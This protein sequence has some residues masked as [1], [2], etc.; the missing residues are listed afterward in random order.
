MVAAMR[1]TMAAMI[2]GGGTNRY[3]SVSRPISPRLVSTG[4]LGIG[5]HDQGLK[6]VVLAAR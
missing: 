3:G 4:V 5:G 1:T 6:G 2:A